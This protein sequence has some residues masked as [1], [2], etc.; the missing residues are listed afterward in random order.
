M[1]SKLEQILKGLVCWPS[2]PA[3]KQQIIQAKLAILEV[4]RIKEEEIE[5]IL[6]KE[7]WSF[8]VK[9]MPECTDD[10]DSDHFGCPVYK[11]NEDE[12]KCIKAI[13]KAFVDDIN[14][15]MGEL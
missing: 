7:L 13:A 5:K 10:V 4:V 8:I 6:N 2:D 14:S 15:K 1:V 3:S 9:W 12:S 11:W